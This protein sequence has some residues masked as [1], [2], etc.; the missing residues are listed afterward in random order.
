MRFGEVSG[1]GT[2]ALCW[3]RGCGYRGLDGVRE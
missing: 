2:G 1:R 3:V